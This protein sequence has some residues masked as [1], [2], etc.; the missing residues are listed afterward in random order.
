M[1]VL[2]VLSLSYLV[3]LSDAGALRPIADL[4]GD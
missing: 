2:H 3:E 4:E 1:V